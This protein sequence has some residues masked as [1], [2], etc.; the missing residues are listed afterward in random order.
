MCGPLCVGMCAGVG[1]GVAVRVRLFLL[2]NCYRICDL[3]WSTDFLFHFRRLTDNN[4]HEHKLIEQTRWHVNTYPHT[5]THTHTRSVEYTHTH[6][7][8]MWQQKFLCVCI[9]FYLIL[10]YSGNPFENCWQIHNNCL[11]LYA[12][13][14]VYECACDVM[15]LCVGVFG[16][17]LCQSSLLLLLFL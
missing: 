9:T 4:L 1:V 7:L 17:L 14:C 11:L 13:G 8:T 6:T 15:S 16:N 10:F 5:S 3:G 2:F 12:R